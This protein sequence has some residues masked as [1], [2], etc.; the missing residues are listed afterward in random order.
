MPHKHGFIRAFKK[1]LGLFLALYINKNIKPI[2]KTGKYH[3]KHCLRLM[4]TF[5]RY[6]NKPEPGKADQSA[7]PPPSI[8]QQY[9]LNF[10]G[11]NHKIMDR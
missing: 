7:P 3:L 11:H 6:R 10:G 5:P 8:Q 2:N 4:P 1:I 9:S